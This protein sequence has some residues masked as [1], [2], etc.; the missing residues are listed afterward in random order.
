MAWFVPLLV[1]AGAGVAGTLAAQ[2]SKRARRHRR[3][4]G[5]IERS[6]AKL[7]QLMGAGQQPK[8]QRAKRPAE[9]GSIVGAREAREYVERY[10]HEAERSYRRYGL[11]KAAE[12]EFKHAVEYGF[13][14]LTEKDLKAAIR[15]RARAESWHT[16]VPERRASE[17]K[18]PRSMPGKF[19][20]R[21]K[22]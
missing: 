1:G 12:T 19:I 8:T 22:A 2:A 6:S 20:P 9:Q 4:L 3:M 10:P 15:E 7:E 14:W 21:E 17:A 16:D 13:E 11:T 5:A 18:H